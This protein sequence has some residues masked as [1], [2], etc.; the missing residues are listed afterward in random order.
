MKKFILCCAV[1]G[2]TLGLAF[3]ANVIADDEK[4]PAEIIIQPTAKKVKKSPAQFPHAK[5]QETME[6]AECHHGKDDAGKQIDYVEGQKI[7]K[8]STCHNTEV[9]AGKKKGKLKL[10]TLKGAAHGKCKACHTAKS[11]EDEKFKKLKKCTN[12]HPKKKK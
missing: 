3:S 11:K 6:C 2:L 5:H 8:C 4:G 12:C 9:L 1:F 10:D 7:E